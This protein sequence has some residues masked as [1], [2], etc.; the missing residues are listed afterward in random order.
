MLAC[1]LGN[2][3]FYTLL[4]EVQLPEGQFVNVHQS[5]LL[6]IYFKEIIENLD[7]VKTTKMFITVLFII[8]I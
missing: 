4:V 1:V 2:K 6:E 7:K 5:S 8:T 3:H